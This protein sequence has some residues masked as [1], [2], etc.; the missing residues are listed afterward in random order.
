MVRSRSRSFI[1]DTSSQGE[2]HLL[3]ESRPTVVS[4]TTIFFTFLPSR[5]P[6]SVSKNDMIS[7]LLTVSVSIISHRPEQFLHHFTLTS[8]TK[9]DQRVRSEKISLHDKN[10]ELGGNFAY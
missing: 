4:V 5:Q 6:S 8:S 10:R 9:P 2:D 7:L 3:T 1:L